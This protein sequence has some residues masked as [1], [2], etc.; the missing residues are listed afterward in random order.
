MIARM[1][2]GAR[3]VHQCVA[4]PN[5]QVKWRHAIDSGPH[6]DAF[7]HAERGADDPRLAQSFQWVD[8]EPVLAHWAGRLTRMRSYDASIPKRR[9]RDQQVVE[10]ATDWFQ[11]EMGWHIEEI[12]GATSQEELDK[13]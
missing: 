2:D 11:D 4:A 7:G 1:G 12:R 3:L 10:Q 5:L 8:H 13:A 6:V 9:R